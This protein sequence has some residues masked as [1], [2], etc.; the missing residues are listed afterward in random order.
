MEEEPLKR[1]SRSSEWLIGITIRWQRGEE[2][3]GL[4]GTVDDTGGGGVR[5][6]Y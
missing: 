1:E 5:K 4:G 6:V 3:E 2:E